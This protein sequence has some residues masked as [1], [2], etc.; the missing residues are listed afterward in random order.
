[1]KQVLGLLTFGIGALFFI[2]FFTILKP[3]VVTA[4]LAASAGMPAFSETVCTSSSMR[5]SP[6]TGQAQQSG[7]FSCAPADRVAQFLRDRWLVR[8]G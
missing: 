3:T 8:P 4:A 2:A 6:F 5:I 7:A 1:M